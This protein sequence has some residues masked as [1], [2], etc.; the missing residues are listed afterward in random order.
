MGTG[1]Q[2]TTG[3]SGKAISARINTPFGLAFNQKQGPLYITEQGGARVRRV[4]TIGV[5]STAATS[6][7]SLRSP[8][9]I[10]IDGLSNLYVTDTQTHLVLKFPLIGESSFL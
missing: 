1:V 2:G 6:Y 9:G 7:S 3:D 4:D 5:I 10:A 8:A